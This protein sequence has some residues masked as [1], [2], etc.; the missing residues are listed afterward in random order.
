MS[1]QHL[2]ICAAPS[3]RVTFFRLI[4]RLKRSILA[5]L[6]ERRTRTSSLLSEQTSTAEILELALSPRVLGRRPSR[7]GRQCNDGHLCHSHPLQAGIQALPT[8]TRVLSSG[9]ALKL[10]RRK[11][12]REAALEAGRRHGRLATALSGSGRSIQS[13]WFRHW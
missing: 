2:E 10:L 8:E 5:F 11:H 7:H 1:W 12:A 4:L 6:C 9:D 3:G 13:I